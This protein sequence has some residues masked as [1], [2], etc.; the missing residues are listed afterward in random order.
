MQSATKVPPHNIEAEKSLLGSVLI[1]AHSF[2]KIG[3]MIIPEDFYLE[4]HRTIFNVMLDLFNRHQP[5][6]V[7]TMSNRLE[8]FERLETIGGRSYLVELGNSVSTSSHIINYGTIIKKKS[9]LRR[10][11]S[12]AAEISEISFNEEDDIETIIDRAEH[13]LF[14]V[15][16]AGTNQSFVPVTNILSEAFERIDELH[17]EKG[18]MRGVPSGFTG[19]DSLLGGFQKSDLIILAARP[20]VGKTAFVLDL[21]RQAALK[22]KLPVALFSLEMSKEQLVDRMISSEANVDL[23]KMRT[24]RLSDQGDVD[25][26]TR[27]GHALGVL[28]EAP[29]YIDDTPVTTVTAIRTKT[30]RLQTEHGLGMVIIDYLQLIDSKTNI[31]NR[32]QEI[33]QI[34]RSLKTL[35]RELNIPVIA[36][37]QLSRS[38][39]MTKPAIPRLSHL[40][41]SGSIEQDADI[42]MFIYRK[43]ADR[44][45]RLEDIPPEERNIAEIHIA[46]HR[47][48]PTG[49]VKLFF[50][51]AR[52]SFKNLD[53]SYQEKPQQPP[54]PIKP[55]FSQKPTTTYTP[56]ATPRPQYGVPRPSGSS[57]PTIARPPAN[58]DIPEM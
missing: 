18:K 41:D 26:F 58:P 16:S 8:E 12:A 37:S 5:I 24:G 27:I 54:T 43:A 44:N 19:L 23:W 38:V 49:V 57:G 32:V 48:G 20:S 28:A 34:S 7:L 3:D 21:A 22:S 25:D 55:A 30:R 35:A 17:R 13:S 14:A 29:I 2:I 51:S 11:L 4:A 10:L 6:D 9:T 46:K 52:V 39:E 15:S 33:S 36:L 45:Y 56:G 53:A 40:R 50:D 42:V 47:N 31:E 1:D